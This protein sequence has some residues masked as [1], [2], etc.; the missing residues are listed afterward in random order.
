MSSQL[1]LI[2]PD[3]VILLHLV[4]YRSARAARGVDQI[5]RSDF[6]SCRK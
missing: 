1:V 3:F 2:F 4:Y 6:R 5:F